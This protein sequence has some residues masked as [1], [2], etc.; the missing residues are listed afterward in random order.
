MNDSRARA[1]LL[2]AA[3]SAIV[4]HS[5]GVA[6]AQDSPAGDPPG[7]V[8]P[9]NATASHPAEALLEHESS[10]VTQEPADTA[11]AEP[12]PEGSH[13]EPMAEADP[14][15]HMKLT[16]RIWRAKSGFA[17]ARTPVGTLTLFSK[18]GL[19]QVKPGQWVTVWTHGSNIVVDVFNKGDEA[20]LY[21]FIT[22]TPVYDS[23][24]QRRLTLWTPEGGMT[25]D[26]A[27]WG[28]DLP[29]P[30][31]GTPLTVRLDQSGKIVDAPQVN[32]DIQISNGTKKRE[33]T[34]MKLAGTVSRVKAG[35]AFID[36]PI[37]ALTLSRS[38]GLRNAKA[39]QEVTVWLNDEHLVID[40]RQKGN[41]GPNQ[42]F[43]TSTVVYASKDKREIKL[44]TPEGERIFQLPSGKTA[45]RPF[46][47]GTP[48]TIQLNGSG[49]VVDVRKAS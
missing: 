24:D 19:R 2:A 4:C 32:V 17:F 25:V 21:R 30:Q 1:L 23:P 26:V 6:S 11:T 47:E 48:V 40:V 31:E 7:A 8:A 12:A 35:F 45:R 10:Q 38:T 33:G 3:L 39:G 9:I 14:P 42:R 44:W 49:E 18:Q 46:R 5:G 13:D 37:G 28:D 20:P 41:P 27:Q 43:I 36:T 29:S 34:H 22:A 15:S 16:G